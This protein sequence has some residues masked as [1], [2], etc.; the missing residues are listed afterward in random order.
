MRKKPLIV[1][2]AI[3]LFVSAFAIMSASS[4]EDVETVQDSAFKNMM[5]PPAVFFHDEHNENAQIEECNVCH[6]V[7]ED[8]QLMEDESSEDME[9]SE[10]HMQK[11]G[12]NL[13][14]LVKVYHDRCKGC[15]LESKAG[16][17]MCSECHIKTK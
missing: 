8:G 4:Q 14:K 11:D 6:H 13:I 16:P 1:Y 9:C 15:H 2:M 12:E 17:V 10:C 5:R 7:Y 3:T